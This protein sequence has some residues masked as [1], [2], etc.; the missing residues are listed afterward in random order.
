MSLASGP[1]RAGMGQVPAE[2][3]LFVD[4]HVKY[5]QS[6]DTVRLPATTVAP[7]HSQFEL[8]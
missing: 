3:R 6:L 2:M 5:I 8:P 4:K 7:L 1:G